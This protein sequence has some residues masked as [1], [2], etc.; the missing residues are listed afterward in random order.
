MICILDLFCENGFLRAI[1]RPNHFHGLSKWR[2]Y[3]VMLEIND[4]I[5][6]I[7]LLNVGTVPIVWYIVSFYYR[8]W[9][10]TSWVAIVE[11]CMVVIVFRSTLECNSI[12]IKYRERD[13]QVWKHFKVYFKWGWNMSPFDINSVVFHFDESNYGRRSQ[14]YCFWLD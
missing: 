9:K 13:V 10:K 6:K 1:S 2:V 5:S 3:N 7:F 12:V 4:N 14:P 11:K 8:L